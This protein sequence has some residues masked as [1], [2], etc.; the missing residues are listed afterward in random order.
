MQVA[1]NALVSQHLDVVAGNSQA[2]LYTGR[3]SE[4]RER[5]LRH[6]MRSLVSGICIVRGMSR[7]YSQKTRRTIN[8]F[9]AVRTSLAYVKDGINN[10]VVGGNEHGVNSQK[11]GTKSSAQ[12]KLNL[13]AGKT[14]TI[15]L[16]LSDKPPAAIG[17]PFLGF[18]TTMKSRQG[19]A[20]E[21]IVT[22]PRH[23]SPRMRQASC[24]KPW[25]VCSGPN[26]IS[27]LT[28]TNGSRSMVMIR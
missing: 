28:S 6:L 13:G 12:Y 11:T 8:G 2:V 25:P 9:S 18:A 1:A 7:S 27:S 4:R 17:D 21:P 14:A 15:R 10:Y 5:Q 19:E 26:S 24:A 16:R 20:D 3:G 23:I 22:L